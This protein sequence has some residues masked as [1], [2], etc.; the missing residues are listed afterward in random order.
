MALV[1]KKTKPQKVVKNPTYSSPP[2]PKKPKIPA[3]W[4]GGWKVKPNLD[5]KKFK[6][7]RTGAGLWIAKPLTPGAGGAAA[8]GSAVTPGPYDQYKKTAPW[9]I[10]GLQQLDAQQAAHQAYVSDKV[11]P[12]LSSGLASLTGVDPNQPGYNPVLQQQYQANIQGQ[13]GGSLNAAA[14]AT[15]LAPASVTPGGV[16]AAPNAYQGAAMREASAQRGGAAILNAQAQ[17]ALN[18]LGPNIFSQAAVMQMADYAKGLPA[19]YVQ[20]RA[21]MRAKIDQWV[22]EQQT[23]Q[24]AAAETARHN[25]VTEAISAQNSATSAAIQLGHLGIDT[26]KANQ[27]SAAATSPAPYGYNRDPATGKLVR[28]PSIPQASASSGGSSGS[29]GPS[30]SKGQYPSNV[31]KKQGYVG[32]WK[33][34]PAARPSYAKGSYVRAT[35]GSWWIKPGGST[36]AK[37]AKAKP[38]VDQQSVFTK[39]QDQVN[40]LNISDKQ[41]VGTGDLLRFLKP[42][43]PAKGTAWKKWYSELLSTLERV[44]PAYKQWIA[45]WV[46]RRI[47]D[48]TFK[49]TF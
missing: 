6:V 49:G 28:D 25:S 14:G 31:L 21:D 33:V 47:K 13:V 42:L 19:V 26:T 12:W 48:G 43:Q 27:T 32:G 40:K 4:K 1:I 5:P 11:M 20:K 35:D 22:A 9:A 37:P 46:Q 30:A 45:G 34:K 44:D 36:S 38:V 41:S 16:V 24:A 18:T 10:P 17:S 39:L 7:V 29:K 2:P 15:P 3:G 8:S 23:A